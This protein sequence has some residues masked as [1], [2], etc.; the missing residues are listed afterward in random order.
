MKL[1]IIGSGGFAGA[2]LRYTLSKFFNE[3][4]AFL[5]YPI[6]TVIVNITGTFFLCLLMGLSIR[7][8]GIS[9]NMTLFFCTGFLG[10]FTTFS[11]FIF[12]NIS[13]TQNST[14]IGFLIYFC[15]SIVGSFLAGIT[16]LNLVKVL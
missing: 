9:K 6:G 15:L 10:S 7:E 4:Y 13:L 8:F 12:E 2:I 16:A 3:R 1:L 11:T 14:H 5:N